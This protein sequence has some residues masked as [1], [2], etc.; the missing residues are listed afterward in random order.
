MARA[1]GAGG[2][3]VMVKGNST[4]RGYRILPANDTRTGGFTVL[5]GDFFTP[6]CLT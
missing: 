1:A 3:Q 6:Y 5:R 4:A 2:G